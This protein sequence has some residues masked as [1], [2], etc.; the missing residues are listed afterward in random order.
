[1]AHKSAHRSVPQSWTIDRADGRDDAF[2][3]AGLWHHYFGTGYSHNALPWPLHDAMGWDNDDNPLLDSCGVVARHRDVQIGGGIV[4]IMDHAEAVD[5]LPDGR[6]DAGALAGDRNAYL[7][8]GAVDPAWRGQGI[9]RA[10]FERR[11]EWAERHGAG[12]V[13][14]FGWERH[15]GRTSRPLFEA[16]DFV[17]IQQFPKHYA[18]SR[19]ACPDCGSWPSND[20]ACRC[21]MTL[22]ARELPIETRTIDDFF[23][24][25]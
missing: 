4:S 6:F 16:Y 7:C 11:L 3:L 2:Y 10:L 13:F 21:E 8:F 18:E 24:H 17:P 19:D 9:G 14:A 15:A 1:M 25:S 12:M 5:E 22:W 20:V 23:T